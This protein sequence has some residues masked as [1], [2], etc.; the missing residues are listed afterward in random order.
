M[1]ELVAECHNRSRVS[2]LKQLVRTYLCCRWLLRFMH[3]CK[4]FVVEKPLQWFSYWASVLVSL[5]LQFLRLMLQFWLHSAFNLLHFSSIVLS[6]SSIAA[7]LILNS[8]SDACAQGSDSDAIQSWVDL[9]QMWCYCQEAVN[10]YSVLK[11]EIKVT[12]N[13]K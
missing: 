1:S 11:L 5:Y 12:I 8:E 9:I 4:I 6:S 7:R 3:Y 2:K 10:C 13:L